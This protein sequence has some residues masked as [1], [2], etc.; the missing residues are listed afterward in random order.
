MFNI[1]GNRNFIFISFSFLNIPRQK[2]A[3]IGRLVKVP[4]LRK[5]KFRFYHTSNFHWQ[6]FLSINEV[7]KHFNISVWQWYDI[8]EYLNNL[9]KKENHLASKKE[10]KRKAHI[11]IIYQR[12]WQ[13]SRKMDIPCFFPLHFNFVNR[14]KATIP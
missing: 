2:D 8:R 10:K 6:I 5:S 9:Y 14:V 7:S 12:K 11:F 13:N 4:D 1:Q 3:K